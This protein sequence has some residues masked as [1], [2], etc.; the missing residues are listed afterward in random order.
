MVIYRALNC[1]RVSRFADSVK[2]APFWRTFQ[3]IFAVAVSNGPNRLDVP[4]TDNHA[5]ENCLQVAP[6]TQDEIC[7]V[8]RFLLNKGADP[9]PVNQGRTPIDIAIFLPIDKSSGPA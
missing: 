1:R 4:Q 8:I 2:R 7:D 3:R 5:F 9:D 6:A